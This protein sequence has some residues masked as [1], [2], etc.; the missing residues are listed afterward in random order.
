[1]KKAQKIIENQVSAIFYKIGNGIQFNI[2]N[3]GKI[4]DAAK[5]VLI[6]GGSLQ[7]AET[8]MAVAIAQYKEN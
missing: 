7:A 4:S 8:A 3:L 6:A 2:M 1:M 5:N